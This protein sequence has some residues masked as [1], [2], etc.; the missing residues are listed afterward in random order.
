MDKLEQRERQRQIRTICVLIDIVELLKAL[1]EILREL[2][3]KDEVAGMI[4]IHGR[5]YIKLL[6]K[7]R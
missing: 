2:G 7:A 3:R 4:V 5:T 1:D 6:S